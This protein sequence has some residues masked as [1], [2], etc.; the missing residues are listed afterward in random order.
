MKTRIL[1]GP[2]L[3]QFKDL[4]P[5]QPY[6]LTH[7]GHPVGAG[8]VVIEGANVYCEVDVP[9]LPQQSPTQVSQQTRGG[10]TNSMESG[11]LTQK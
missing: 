8:I 10:H 1:I 4:Q 3:A 11:G 5:G 9:D 2:R 7:D 6:V